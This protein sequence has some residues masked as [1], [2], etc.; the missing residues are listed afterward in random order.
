MGSMA[1]AEAEAGAGSMAG[2]GAGAHRTVLVVSVCV[3]MLRRHHWSGISW[4]LKLWAGLAVGD[5]DGGCSGSIRHDVGVCVAIERPLRRVTTQANAGAETWGRWSC[6]FGSDGT[7]GLT[8]AAPK[9]GAA[10]LAAICFL[11]GRTMCARRRA[12]SYENERLDVALRGLPVETCPHEPSTRPG[13]AR[14]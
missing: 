7:S 10:S 1:G 12:T 3:P 6:S 2:A 9:L 13:V 14:R 5:V 8:A 4:R 11:R